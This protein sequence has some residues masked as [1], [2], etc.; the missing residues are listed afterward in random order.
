MIRRTLGK[1]GLE[2]SALGFGT[3]EFRSVDEKTAV[4]ILNGVLDR[5]ISYIDTSPEYPKAEYFIGQA[6]SKRRDEYTLA[7]K[8][9][10]NMSGIG[11]TY[12]F[13]RKTIID[14]VEESL[15]LMKTDHL[16]VIQLH[17][18]IPEYLPGGPTGEA[19]ETLRDLKKAGKVLHIG[20]T[21]CQKGPEF[22]GSPA[23]YGYNSI[24]RFAPW[25]DMEII[26]LVYGCMTRLS[27]NVIQAA[28]DRYKTGIV[29]RG[30]VKPY[31][32][33]YNERFEV[34]RLGELFEA[35]ET[36]HDFLI[37]YALSHP[38]LSNLLVGTKQLGHLDENIRA[39]ERGPLKPAVYQEAKQ[40]MNF[41]GNIAGPVD[42][43]LDW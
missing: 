21:I 33:T 1:T 13:D 16:D 11:P 29:A 32:N 14:N 25:P 22:Y 15:R 24:L 10:D 37:R 2:V 3:M 4:A 38:G 5:G 31:N 36:R 17:G 28:Y 6:I 7:T 26:Q 12:V 41:T 19:W 43:K 35:G 42:M 40:R 34:S 18:V 30:I 39:V 27:E 9:G 8:C 20:A 23:A